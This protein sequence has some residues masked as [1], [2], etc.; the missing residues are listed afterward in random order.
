MIIK[1]NSELLEVFC[2]EY[3]IN[4]LN[5]IEENITCNTKLTAKCINESCNE[6]FTK[7]FHVLYKSKIFTC[8]KCTIIAGQQKNKNTIMQKYGVEFI[9]QVSD[10]KEKKKETCLQKYG[11]DNVLKNKDIINKIKN[12][13]NLNYFNKYNKIAPSLFSADEKKQMIVDKYGTLN[14]RSS[15]YVKNKIKQTV[16]E[17]YGVD[18][19]SKRKDIQLLKR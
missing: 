7:K 19:I 2:K 4:L 6:T 13:N 3:N 18:H 15:D 10:V 8:K 14:F 11:V 1:F 12:T 16:M 17:K 9:G 5:K